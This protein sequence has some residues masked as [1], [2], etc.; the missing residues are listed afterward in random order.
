MAMASF[1]VRWVLDG[2]EKTSAVHYDRPA[3]E[4]RQRELAQSGAAA[5]EIFETTHGR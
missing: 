3:A 5:V 2:Q 1:K 4:Q